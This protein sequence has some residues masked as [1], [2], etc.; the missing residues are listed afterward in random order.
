MSCK[1]KIYEDIFSVL[2][3]SCMYIIIITP[4]NID[5]PGAHETTTRA[6]V[7]GNCDGVRMPLEPSSV[8]AP[9]S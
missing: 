3:I 9:E 7:R 8:L 6:G 5:L 2:H 1:Y 4:Y